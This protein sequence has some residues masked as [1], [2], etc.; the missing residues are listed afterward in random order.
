MKDVREPFVLDWLLTGDPAVRWQALRDLAGRGES[1]VQREQKQIAAAGWGKRLL[2]LQDADG[3]WA[4]GLYTPKWTSTTY[5]LVLLRSFGLAPGHPQALR[6]CRILLDKGCWSDGGINFYPRRYQHSETCIS[7]MVLGVAC[8]FGVDDPRVDRL[9]D[10]LLQHQL[11]DGGWNCRAMPGYG[12]ATHS[13][14]H[15]TISAL[16]ALWDY[17]QFRPER[18]SLVSLP[19]PRG[20]EFLLVHRLFR[21]HRTGAIARREFLRFSFPPR[22]HYDVLRGLDYFVASRA[23]PD[24]RLE[25][26]LAMVQRKRQPDGR[27]LLALPHRGATFFELEKPGDASRWNTLRALRV[28]RWAGIG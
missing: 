26:G 6:G 20:R 17:Q 8:W 24:D 18:A 1:A 4:K 10:H 19:Q 28:L 5:T 7:A 16:E 25:D 22:W 21:S 9:A 14:F 23:K 11:A 27:W 15:T 2:D 12:G 3:R 13:S